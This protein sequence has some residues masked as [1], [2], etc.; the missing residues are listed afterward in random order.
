[1]SN[2]EKTAVLK[3][4]LGPYRCTG[5]ELL[6]HCPKCDH[7]KNKLSVNLNKNVF[8]CWICDYRSNNI[9]R[10]VRRFGNPQQKTTWSELTGQID[11]GQFES[12]IESLFPETEE[13]IP[14][15]VELPNEFVSLANKDN[16][17]LSI[18]AKNYLKSRG[19]TDDDILF[20]KI[21]FCSSGEYKGRIIIPSFNESGD[22]NFFIARTY[23]GDWR[24]YM[25]PKSSK[26][27][28][29][30]NELYVDWEED[31]ILTEGIFDAIVAGKNSVP[32]LGSSL[33]EQSRLFRSI[34]L[35]DTP[36]FVAL[37]QDA[38]EKAAILIESLIKYGAEVY[39]IDISPYSDVG[40][41][42][43]KEFSDRKSKA[44]QVFSDD[45]FYEK[46][47]NGFKI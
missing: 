30:F 11:I 41:M 9:T 47:L 43:K 46:I 18:K 8:K 21:G 28:I 14:I 36:V 37:D 39:K 3:Q 2:K 13:E 44:I 12:I 29:I 45:A 34:I 38:Q 25:N 26:S 20:W 16:S 31:L 17:A 1:M 35:N 24:K 42:P 7:H 32:I 40:E 15:T 4:I 22:C 23:T 27:K 33:K 6:F 10:L 19:I 5:D